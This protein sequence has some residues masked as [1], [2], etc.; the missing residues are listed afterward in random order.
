[1]ARR[2]IRDFTTSADIWPIVEA[3]AKESD[4]R[5]KQGGPATRLYQRGYGFLTAP[6]MLQIGQT[7]GRMHLEA[8][9][10]VGLLNRLMALFLVPAEMGIESG[11][12]RLVVPRNVA[13]PAVNKLLNQLGQP[14]IE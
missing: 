11:G 14:P 5:L 13:R 9:I 1:M 7:E 2:T 12:F 8:W 4:F 3:W 10:R 6:M